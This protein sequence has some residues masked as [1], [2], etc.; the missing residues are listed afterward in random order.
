[1]LMASKG[2]IKWRREGKQCRVDFGS[3]GWLMSRLHHVTH[4][5]KHSFTLSLRQLASCQKGLET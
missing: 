3:S 2:S 1:M 5:G 4:S